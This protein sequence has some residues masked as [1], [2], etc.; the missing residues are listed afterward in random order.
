MED[1]LEE[2]ED[3]A[4]ESGGDIVTLKSDELTKHPENIAA[5]NNGIKASLP[6]TK[7]TMTATNCYKDYDSGLKLCDLNVTRLINSFFLAPTGSFGRSSK[8]RGRT[9]R[10]DR[11]TRTRAASDGV[12]V[13]TESEVSHTVNFTAEQWKAQCAIML[14]PVLDLI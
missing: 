12:F 7:M 9:E 6:T 10:I 2:F 11:T 5:F 13:C 8:N 4:V 14:Y 1:G 3:K